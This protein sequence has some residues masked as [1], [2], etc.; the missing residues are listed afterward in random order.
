[1]STPRRSFVCVL[2]A[3]GFSLA[4]CAPAAPLT[5]LDVLVPRSTAALGVTAT[6][7]S[8]STAPAPSPA[9]TRVPS[10]AAHLPVTATPA[11]SPTSIPIVANKPT[12]VTIAARPIK[13]AQLIGDFDKER[14][15][16]TANLTGARYELTATDLGIPFRHKDR[17]FILFGDSFGGH[18]GDAIAFTSDT[19][20]DDGLDLQ[21]VTDAEGVYKPIIIP[22][23]RQDAFEVPTEGV[24]VGNRM[25]V[26]HTT[27]SS[28]AATMGRSVLAVSDDDGLTFKYLYD[29]SRQYFI[30]VSI[31]QQG[32]R[33]MTF[34][35]GVYRQSNVYLAAQPATEINT[36]G[37]LRYYTGLD[38][39][40]QPQWSGREQDARALFDQ[41]CVGEFSVSYNRFIDKWIMLYNCAR[42]QARGILVRTADQPWGPWSDAQVLFDPWADN[43]YCHFMH[44]IPSFR[45]CDAVNDAGQENTWGGEY[46]PYQFEDLATGT[47]TT[48]TIYFTLSTWNPYTV[49]LMK[50]TL[51]IE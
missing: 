15:Q 16:P 20:P 46:G 27:D 40:G 7:V 9:A 2:F 37:S 28:A 49:V 29:V 25:Y 1:M 48:T 45:Q 24:S 17:T 14:N 47:R 12:R 50:A 44:T 35:S 13:I 4:A 30:N 26:Y 3:L 21:F 18:G 51:A 33:L 31:V 19:H 10:T 36:R 6:A 43:G 5:P 34:G 39:A 32:D 41:P 8:S 42:S 11:P 22:G 23:I 38:K